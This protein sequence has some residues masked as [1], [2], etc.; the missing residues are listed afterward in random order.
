MEGNL[1]TAHAT[2]VTFFILK[3]YTNYN[4]QFELG[5]KTI[6]SNLIFNPFEDDSMTMNQQVELLDVAEQS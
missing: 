6:K 1:V 2:A 4:Y 5:I 3:M